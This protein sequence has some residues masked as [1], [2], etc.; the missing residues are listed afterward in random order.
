MKLV[1]HCPFLA[2]LF[3]ELLQYPRRQGENIKVSDA[4]NV[5]AC[6][7]LNIHNRVLIFGMNVRYGYNIGVMGSNLK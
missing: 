4:S 7:S 1:S 2:R 3:E 5:E 6:H